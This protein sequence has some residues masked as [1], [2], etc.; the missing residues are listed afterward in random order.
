[1]TETKS[2]LSQQPDGFGYFYGFRWPDSRQ[3]NVKQ[4]SGHWAAWVGGNRVVA[5]R[6]KQEAEAMAIAWMDRNPE[7]PHEG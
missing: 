5:A 4:E 1:M 3:I 6:D 7:E 2:I